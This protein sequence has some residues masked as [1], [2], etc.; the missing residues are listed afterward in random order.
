MR[1]G[2]RL[3]GK[4][5]AEDSDV[6]SSCDSSDDDCFIVDDSDSDCD[7][8]GATGSRSKSKKKHGHNKPRRMKIVLDS[9][10]DEEDTE[11]G[12]SG[13]GEGMDGADWW[14]WAGDDIQVCQALCS[15]FDHDPR[16]SGLVR[17]V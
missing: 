6:S 2:S 11:E 8:A 16:I 3:A 13:E 9:D 17:I 5:S 10:D 14:T 12:I 4:L 15:S 7:D 1:G